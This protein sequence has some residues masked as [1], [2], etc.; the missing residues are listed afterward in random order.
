[1]ITIATKYDWILHQIYV[2]SSFLNGEL[3]EE[4]Y[5]EQPEGFFKPGQE[6]LVCK[7]KKSLCGLKQN[8]RSW[9]TKIDNLSIQQ[10]FQR[11]NSDPNLYVKEDED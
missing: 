2:K 3:K 7:L 9:Y 10:G 1:M 8:P 6:H 11:S 5:L 4:I